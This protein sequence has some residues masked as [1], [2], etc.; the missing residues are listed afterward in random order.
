MH[1]QS[2]NYRLL[3]IR[4]PDHGSTPLLWIAVTRLMY[5]SWVE[6]WTQLI[7]LPL[8]SLNIWS[9]F[10]QWGNSRTHKQ[11]QCMCLSMAGNCKWFRWKYNRWLLIMTQ[12]CEWKSVYRRSSDILRSIFA[13]SVSSSWL[14]YFMLWGQPILENSVSTACSIWRMKGEISGHF[15]LTFTRNI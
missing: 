1:L 9:H 11:L 15:L 6:S 5:Q 14:R 2:F 3:T 7:L 10:W 8:R 12:Y 13:R 4:Y